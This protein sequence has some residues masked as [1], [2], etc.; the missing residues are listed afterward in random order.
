MKVAISKRGRFCFG[1]CHG[2]RCC[3]YNVI[4]RVMLG[5]QIQ[6]LYEIEPSEIHGLTLW[7]A[8]SADEKTRA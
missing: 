3:S 2:R 7:A 8:F 1:S 6:K 5:E 4:D